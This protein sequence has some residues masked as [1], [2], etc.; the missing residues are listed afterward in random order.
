MKK[1]DDITPHK[2]LQYI[3]FCIYNFPLSV[4]HVKNYVAID[5]ELLVI[6]L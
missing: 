6:I 2:D 3:Y 4:P 5:Y 1:E